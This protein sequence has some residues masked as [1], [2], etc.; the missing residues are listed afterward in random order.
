MADGVTVVSCLQIEEECKVHCVKEWSAYQV[1]STAAC[2][3]NQRQGQRVVGSG[4][5]PWPELTSSVLGEGVLASQRSSWAAV[6]V[7]GL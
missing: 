4:G 5:L 7:N 1:S 3:N 2:W 6:Q